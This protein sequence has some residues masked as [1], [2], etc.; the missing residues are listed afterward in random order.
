MYSDIQDQVQTSLY[1]NKR[2]KSKLLVEK[3][4]FLN[5]NTH[6]DKRSIRIYIL[7]LPILNGR[8]YQMSIKN[9]YLLKDVAYDDHDHAHT[10]M[11]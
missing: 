11:A 1:K 9:M 8:K 7:L 5:H 2:Y 3:V 10:K 6:T 4:V